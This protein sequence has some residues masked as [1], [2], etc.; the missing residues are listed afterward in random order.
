MPVGTRWNQ[1]LEDL[2][3]TMRGSTVF[4]TGEHHEWLTVI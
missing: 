2:K 1:A 4:T 3:M